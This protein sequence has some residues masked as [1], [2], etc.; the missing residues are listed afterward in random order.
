MT[1]KEYE[2]KFT[3]LL[4]FAPHLI[5][6]ESDKAKKFQRGL[7]GNIRGKLVALR[8]RN[9]AE[10]VETAF[11]IEKDLLEYQEIRNKKQSLVKRP[12]TEGGLTTDKSA[13]NQ[14]GRS[15][16]AKFPF[17]H[18]RANQ[19]NKSA[20]C[21]RCGNH[22]SGYCR[23]HRA[24]F[25][26][27]QPGHFKRDCPTLRNQAITE[28]APR[29]D[30]AARANASQQSNAPQRKAQSNQSV[31]QNQ[32]NQGRVFALTRKDAQASPSVVEGTVPICSFT[33]HALFNPG[34]THSLYHLTLLGI[35][36]I[37]RHY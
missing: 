9:Y 7:R 13:S 25:E 11:E 35:F 19:P 3:Q 18:D 20:A 8:I 6:E 29:G 31:Q 2:A 27:G 36:P 33:A 12:R 34:S 23:L 24:C 28:R 15:A 5:A 37:H 1:V 30:H 32:R 16:T 26:C 22:H 21:P 10:L 17:R 4:R 14:P